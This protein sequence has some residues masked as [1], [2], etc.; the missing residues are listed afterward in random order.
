MFL[1][2]KDHRKG[3]KI[4]NKKKFKKLAFKKMKRTFLCAHRNMHAQF[5][6]CLVRATVVNLVF[7]LVKQDRPS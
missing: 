2:Q 7:H 4:E 6:C 1:E 5:N 3:F